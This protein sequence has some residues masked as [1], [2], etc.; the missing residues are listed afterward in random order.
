MVGDFLE[1]PEVGEKVVVCVKKVLNYGV[2]VSLF[3]YEG[4][5]GFIHISNVSSGWIKNIRNFVKDNQIRVGEVLFVDF[6]KNQVDLSFKKVSSHEENEKLEQWKQFKRTKMLIE[7]MAKK[8]KK[9]F[10]TAW[11]EIAEPL[12][13][14]HGSLLDGF[15]QI[16]LH[17]EKAASTVDKKWIPVL[18][19]VVQKN[20]SLPVKM[21]KATLS[22]K[23]FDSNGLELVKKVL[24]AGEE[25]LRGTNS[26]I[27]YTGSGN[28]AIEVTAADFKDAE[29]ILKKFQETILPLMQKQK[30]VGE[31][32]RENQ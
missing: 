30:I 26:K 11:N 28:Y 1:Y 20:I 31:L 10:D 21:I 17:G 18:L 4:V 12:M 32:K 15:K 6:E 3:E 29:K 5:E 24:L 16:V 9:D 27:Y 13:E 8:E 22:L 7:I 14:E 2:L 19:E 25:S 23:S